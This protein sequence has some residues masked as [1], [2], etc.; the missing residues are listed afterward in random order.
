MQP[1]DLLAAPSES[2]ATDA[3]SSSSP[4]RC[5]DPW[6]WRYAAWLSAR[7]KVFRHAPSPPLPDA[8]SSA[9]WRACAVGGSKGVRHKVHWLLQLP[10]LGHQFIFPSLGYPLKMQIFLLALN[11]SCSSTSSSLSTKR[12]KSRFSAKLS[13]C[14]SSSS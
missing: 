6:T 9:S 14:R 13:S 7:T 1:T 2:P 5:L 8:C 11:V 3:A 4:S 10:T 12:S